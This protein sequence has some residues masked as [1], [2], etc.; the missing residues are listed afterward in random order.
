MIYF[1][2]AF[3]KRVAL[4]SYY[5][6]SFILV[7]VLWTLPSRSWCTAAIFWVA[8]NTMSP[9]IWYVKLTVCGVKI[10]EMCSGSDV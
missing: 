6:N 3:F 2:V 10:N 5:T 7:L 8:L 9:K 1:E 4:E